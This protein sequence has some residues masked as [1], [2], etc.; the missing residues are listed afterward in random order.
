MNNNDDN[1]KIENDKQDTSK[2]ITELMKTDYTY[3]DASDPN[4]QLKIYKKREFYYN[5]IPERPDLTDYNDIKEYRDNTCARKFTLHEH[6]SM[7]SNFIN[8]DTPYRGVLIYHGLGSG[9]CTLGDTMIYIDGTLQPAEDMWKKYAGV[10]F[11]V[12][13]DGG[14]WAKPKDPTLIVNS[15]NN[16]TGKM[17]KQK[18]KHFYREKVNTEL[19]EIKLANG[20]KIT[21]TDQH[22]L[23]TIDGWTR[24]LKVGDYVSIPKKLYNCPE[25]NNLNVTKDLA[26]LIGWQLSE[27]CETPDTQKNN[28]RVIIT[29]NDKSLLEKIRESCIKV[30]M[31][32]NLNMHNM[33]IRKDKRNNTHSL[34]IYSQDYKKFLIDNGYLFGNKSASKQFP[35]FIMNSSMENIKIFLQAYCDAEAHMNPKSGVIELSTASKMISLQLD[36]LFRLFEINPRI[37]EKM[38]CATNGKQIKKKYYELL[39]SSNSLRIFKEKIGFTT[40]YKQKN[41]E[42]ACKKNCNTNLE[43]IPVTNQLNKIYQRVVLP[44]RRFINFS[45]FKYDNVQMPSKQTLQQTCDNINK[46]VVDVPFIKKN[47]ISNNDID[48]LKQSSDKL[49]KESEKEVH[50]VKIEAINRIRYDGYVYDFEVDDTHHNYVGN[51]VLCHNTCVG[52]ALAEKFKEQVQKYNT[53]IYILVSGPLIKESWKHHLVKCTGE[54]YLKYQDQ[55]VYIDEAEKEKQKKNALNNALQYYKFMSYRSFYKRVL[56]EKIRSIN[57]KVIE[58]KNNN[59]TKVSYRKTD[60]GEFERDIAVDRIYNLNNTIIIIDEAHNLTGNAYGDAL[61]HVIKNSTNLRIVLMSATPMKNL[62]D[63]IVELINFIR[64]PEYPIERDKI[65]T[66]LK[67]H[68]MDIKPGGLD[69]FKK[70]AGGYISHVRGSDPLIFARRNDKGE[71]PDGLLFTKVTRCNMLKFQRKTYDSA[72]TESD[73]TLDRRSEAVAN[74]VFPGLSQDRKDLV[75]YYGREGLNL[76]KNQLKISYEQ[77]NKKIATDIFKNEKETDLLYVTQDGK[78]ITGK[79]LKMPYL[80]FFSVKFYKAL[81]KLKRLVWGKKGSKTAFVYSNLVKVGIELFEQIL[82]Q[83]GYLE[84]Q[85]DS[86][87]YQI[88]DETVCYYCGKTRGDHGKLQSRISSDDE[89]SDGS[90]KSSTI[91]TK[92][93]KED[94]GDEHFNISASSSN[95]EEYKKAFMKTDNL[96]AHQFFPAT[97]ITITGK[98]SEESAEVIP[99]DKKRILDNVF[100]ITENNEG[101]YIKLVLGSKVMNEG[102]SLSNVGEVHILD[103]YFNLGKVDQVVGRGIRWC[104]H[105]KQMSEENV[106]PYVNVYKYVVGLEK[107]LSSEEELYQKAEMKYM[108]IKKL[109][110]CMKEIA[111]DCPLNIYGNMFKEEIEKYKNCGEP[112]QEPCPTICDYTKC[113]Y[114]CSDTKLNADYYDPGTNLYKKIKKDNLDYSTF[115]HSLARNEIDN[116]KR[117]IKELYILNYMYTIKEILKYVK[118]SYTDEKKDL[119]NDFF[120]FKALDELIPLTEND[121]NNYKD[122]IIDKH[123]RTGYLIYIDKYY[124]FQPFDQNEDVPMYYRTKYVKS[125]GQQLSLYN[126]LKNTNEYQAF[127]DNRGKKKDND[128]KMSLK[129]EITV[130]NFDDTMEYYDNRDEFKFVGIIDK[131]LSRRKNKQ[132]DDIKDVF[133]IRKHRL[134]ILDKKR[135]TGIPSLKGAVCSTSKNKEYLENIAKQLGVVPKKDETRID[136]CEK[137]KDKMLLLEKYSTGK[138]KVTYV[139]IPENHPQYKFPYN[140]EDRVDFI[141]KKI[142]AEIPLKLDITTKNKKN[143]SEKGI[144]SFYIHIKNSA[145]LSEYNDILKK[146]EAEKSGD[147]WIIKID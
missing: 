136:I 107:G 77:L 112:G 54:T 75:G 29:Q 1:N 138:E 140:L 33:S 72:I 106:F 125:I 97:F 96:P 26:Y 102:I 64:P 135:G 35:Q 124:I 121:F 57:D 11:K 31:V 66:S 147:E 39:I 139:M 129:D 67:N 36:H 89:E 16:D 4:L 19:R 115:T 119:F 9:K 44:K 6:Q 14:Q 42:E 90:E 83:N 126:Y 103:V 48:F 45:Y 105:Y 24:E 37:K 60:E 100:N 20:M 110:R 146:L 92:L 25:K 5:R 132:V 93:D 15:I 78:T 99:E 34:T 134:K 13:E 142:K 76:I 18:I 40:D 137:I 8:P 53:K 73:D 22:K 81:K 86:S 12:D 71:K 79:I 30:G 51:G 111:I 133:K 84:Y 41:L 52:V 43:V 141:I 85:E 2:N 95:Y 108:L 117:K 17:G 61:S 23:L 58:S 131:E 46:V 27:G 21:I 130:Y 80:K 63:D 122:T 144:S 56:G 145:K 65:F 120:V 88:T 109:E 68:M 55:S 69:Y 104:S 47:Y 114:K 127:K 70:M 101:K 128:G 87:N 94:I 49:Y 50:Y 32:Y 82:I 7:L 59:K 28:T 143:G 10:I 91:G 116:A 118:E 3:P 38:K 123:N 74:F 98:S 113:N 62:A